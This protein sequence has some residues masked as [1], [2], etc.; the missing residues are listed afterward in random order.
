MNTDATDAIAEMIRAGIKEEVTRQLDER[1]PPVEP[2]PIGP[3]VVRVE[4]HRELRQAVAGREQP[5]RIELA[6]GGD[7]DG[8]ALAIHGSD[9]EI[10]SVYPLGARVPL[11][12]DFARSSRR[13]ILRDLDLDGPAIDWQG[14]E[15]LIDACRITAA[16]TGRYSVPI[17]PRRGQNCAIRHCDMTMT[18]AD[19]WKPGDMQAIVRGIGRGADE[20]DHMLG[21][22]IDE[23][24]IHDLPTQAAYNNPY[25]CG[26][27]SVMNWDSSSVKTR[28]LLRRCLFERCNTGDK[29]LE[30]KSSENT[31]EDCE[32]RDS[33]EGSICIRQGSN[34]RLI[35]VRMDCKKWTIHRGPGNEALSC[36]WSKRT[37]ARGPMSGKDRWTD[38][39]TN[40]PQAYRA[41]L[42]DCEGDLLFGDSYG[43]SYPLPPLECEIWGHRGEI[44]QKNGTAII[45]DELPA[46]YVPR[47]AARLARDEV[48]LRAA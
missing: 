2:V 40:P 34:N 29:V 17:R 35:G 26:V 21:L 28:W 4:D 8:P 6:S 15:H 32:I 48:G 47:E 11:K 44:T 36:I 7:F 13:I 42:I 12:M 39:S 10:A 16:G 1:L 18:R 41:R 3:R 23:C 27:N 45:H 14:E 30:F 33:P 38:G 31:A 5:M 46:G 25:M 19:H 43:G 20:V 22:L 9:L 37:R 24:Y